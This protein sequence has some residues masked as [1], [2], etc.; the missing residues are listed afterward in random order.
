MTIAFSYRLGHSTVCEIVRETCVAIW[1][2]LIGLYMK[3]PSEESWKS[4]ALDFRK[5]WNFPNCIGAMDGKHVIIQAPPSSGS[6]Y[7]NYKHSHSIV[8][9]AIVSA[10][11]EFV[12]VDIGAYGRNSDGGIFSNSNFGR[13]F[14]CNDLQIPPHAPLPHS[15]LDM[16]HVIVADEAFPLKTG[17]MRPYPGT[18]VSTDKRI[19][20]Y[21]YV[22]V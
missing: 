9:M 21:R 15:E 1:S 22:K 17:I 4:I 3:P 18:N 13:K 11:Y 10:E 16:P 12:M 2:N 19:F 14:L 6:Q 5:R 7:F 8:L 20:N